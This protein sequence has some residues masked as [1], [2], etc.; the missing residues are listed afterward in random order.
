M[1]DDQLR[2]VDD[3]LEEDFIQ[4]PQDAGSAM[5]KATTLKTESGKPNRA[6]FVR[7]NTSAVKKEPK[8]AVQ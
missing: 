8:E 5:V 4:E 1:E 7:S 3:E 6:V 2:E